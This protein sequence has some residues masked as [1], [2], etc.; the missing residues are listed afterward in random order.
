[1]HLMQSVH[2]ELFPATRVRVFPEAQPREWRLH[3]TGRRKAA[4]NS[5]VKGRDLPR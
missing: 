3:R 4:Q 2:E 1:M 5:E